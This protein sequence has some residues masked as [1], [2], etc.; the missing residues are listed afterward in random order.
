M[1]IQGFSTRLIGRPEDVDVQDSKNKFVEDK[2][3]RQ[4]A[5]A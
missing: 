2:V 1:I 5:F 4:L 3:P